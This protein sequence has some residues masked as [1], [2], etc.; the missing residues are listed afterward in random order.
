MERR[1]FHTFITK[2]QA[3]ADK[4]ASQAWHFLYTTKARHAFGMPMAQNQFVNHIKGVQLL[5]TKVGLTHSMKNLVWHHDFDIGTIFPQSFD[6]SDADSAETQDFREDFKFGQVVAFLKT[7]LAAS[8]AFLKKNMVK[9][10]ICVAIAERRIFILSG[11]LLEQVKR[12]PQFTP[13]ELDTVSDDI[14]D[15]LSKGNTAVDFT[16]TSWFRPLQRRFAD[17]SETDMKEK[18]REVLDQLRGLIGENQFSLTDQRNQ[19]IIKPGGKSRGRGI[20]IHSDLGDLL[21]RVRQPGE[22]KGCWVVQKYIER[23]LIVLGKK[24]DV[25]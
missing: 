5:S 19:W 18:V 23:P 14:Y 10:I 25:R 20:E 4:F 8:N 17:T 11:R 21:R 7:A 1:G 15:L 3:E 24:F 2:E 16:K 22:F 6:I 12:D 9:V 13:S